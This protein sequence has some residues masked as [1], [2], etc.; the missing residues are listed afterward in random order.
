MNLNDVNQAPVQPAVRPRVLVLL[1][2]YNAGTWLQ[3]QVASILAQTDVDVQILIGD[4]VSKDDTREFIHRHWG[5][6]ANVRL[7]GW[8]T[9]SGSAGANFRRLYR[10]A[11]MQDYD[12]VALADQ[13]DLWFPHKLINAI[14]AMQVSGAAGYSSAVEA[15]WPDGKTKV[16]GQNATMRQ[17]DFLFE[18][19]GQGCT[20]VVTKELFQRVRAFCLHEHAVAEALHYHDWLIYA[21]ARTW[22]LQWYFDPQPSMRYRQHDNNE[23]GSRGSVASIFKRLK[24]IESGWYR[25]Q[26]RAAVDVADVAGGRTGASTFQKLFHQPASLMRRIRMA[27]YTMR[28]GRRRIADR[29]VLAFASLAGWI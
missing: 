24:M 3:E 4:D 17:G 27:I 26:V 8:D 10:A 1:A 2:T 13:D 6:S 12:F 7:A 23:I 9:P 22:H 25:G 20:F 15:F 16:I 19:A 28:N 5:A 18:G 29:V 11:D 21:L 14:R